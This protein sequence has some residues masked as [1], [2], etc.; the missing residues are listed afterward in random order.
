MKQSKKALA[1]LLSACLLLSALAGCTP[2]KDVPWPSQ[3]PTAATPVQT[4]QT[5]DALAVY[6][7]AAERLM[8]AK[9]L[10]AEY[11][12]EQQITLPDFA[13]PEG[14]SLTLDERITR[15]ARYEGLGSES[16]CAV[17]DD[18]L[19]LG[20]A[21]RVTQ[22]QIYA[23]GVVYVELQGSRYCAQSTGER[24]L[25]EQI[26]PV[27]L[28]ASLYRSL[29]GDTL[30][31][32]LLLR[33][34]EPAAGESW[35]MPEGGSLLE[36][37]GTAS[38][39]GDG[40]LTAASYELRYLF[41]GLTVFTRYEV[42]F[43][44]P[45]EQTLSAS[46]PVSARDYETLD[47]AGAPLLMLRAAYLLDSAAALTATISREIYSEAAGA[48]SR[49]YD[50]LHLLEWDGKFLL[51][52]ENSYTAVDHTKGRTIALGYDADYSDGELRTRSDSGEEESVRLSSAEMS[53]RA[54]YYITRSFPGFDS[55]TDAEI[56]EVGDY[57][58][59]SFSG[60]EDYGLQLKDLACS[61]LFMATPEILDENASA[62]A[63][64]TADGFLAVEK[65]SG[66]PTALNL[67]FTGAH[68]IDDTPYELIMSQNIAL[69]LFTED[70]RE[71]IY[72]EPLP[73][74]E[75]EKRAT[76]VFYEVTDETG[77]KLYL[78][79]TIHI[80]D[81]RTAH[82]PQVIYD[83][84]ESA[85]ALAVEFDTESF[86]DGL[87]ENEELRARLVQS[88]Y[89]MDGTEIRNHLDSE[90]Y[91]AAL[92]LLKVAG[93][94]T[95]TVESMKPYLWSSSIERFYLSQGRRLSS[96]KG[97]D[98]RLMR[99]ARAAD[100]EILDVESGESQIAMLGGYSDPVQA[101]L[102]GETVATSRGDFLNASYELYEAWCTGNEAELTEKLAAMSEEELAELDEDE[103]AAYNE[104]RQKM[105][106]ERNVQMA[107]VAREYLRSGK[108]V[109]YA[110][111]LA[112]LLGEEGLVQALR[113]AG[114]SVELIDTH[115]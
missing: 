27:P 88:Y 113:D 75:P 89:Y 111:G 21:P 12:I 5:P 37:S 15:S 65:I 54:R 110:V 52:E 47:A 60:S 50:I 100:K 84:L 56:K 87:E 3:A 73:V 105:G 10:N 45:E 31:D 74:P 41:G 35:A 104:Y 109:F 83:A 39:S 30:E 115:G 90:L 29:E 114:C 62:Y 66:I 20:K 26:P 22:R 34:E 48:S 85:D 38:I 102:L 46:A 108:T 76:P 16:F 67:E 36:A 43:R 101:M 99:L 53:E 19:I 63:T 32:G 14:D 28:D 55:L 98:N 23:D 44:A 107:E 92:E 2:Q 8:A 82:L 64:R 80:G 61:S 57:L 78:L 95:G 24:F 51:H 59:L 81:D 70:S 4:P 96:D 68:V 94:Y 7:E 97:V 91:K 58:L 18:T 72:D 17:V 40:S 79:G 9:E 93:D 49:S 71:G 11:L 13:D 69:S 42:S 106:P 25:A 112:H 1:L 103:L 33:F 77:G 86:Y 6:E